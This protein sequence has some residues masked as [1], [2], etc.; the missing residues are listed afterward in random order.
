MY[1]STRDFI[2]LSLDGSRELDVKLD[3]DRNVTVDSQLDQYCARPST[4]QFES[5]T[6]L[7]FI[8]RFKTPKKIGDNIICRQKEV[9]VIPRPYCS[10]DPSGPKY[11]QYC[12][13]K[14]MLHQPFRQLD[15]LFGMS[16]TYAAAYS[17]F[18][19]SGNA[20]KSLAEAIYD[21][22]MQEKENR[23]AEV[24][25]ILYANNTDNN[26]CIYSKMITMY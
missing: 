26:T 21:L 10:P 16:D 25:I 1:R 24:S 3:Q 2:N 4:P 11:E 6:L 17:N 14:L 7:Q 5:L 15:E 19:Q 23:D 22:E 13:Q 12:R 8:Q 9:I 20:P 18:I